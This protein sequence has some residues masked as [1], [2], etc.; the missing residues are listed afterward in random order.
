[1]KKVITR[2]RMYSWVKAYPVISKTD[3]MDW[4]SPSELDDAFK[5]LVESRNIGPVLLLNF[6]ALRQREDGR[7]EYDDLGDNL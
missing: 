7:W 6:S 1:M 3:G 2:L 4:L 5:R